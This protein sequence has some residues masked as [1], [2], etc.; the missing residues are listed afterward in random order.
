MGWRRQVQAVDSAVGLPYDVLSNRDCTAA[1]MIVA[2][3]WAQAAGMFVKF[4]MKLMNGDERM[5]SKSKWAG[6]TLGED[7]NT[8]MKFVPHARFYVYRASLSIAPCTH[9]CT[10]LYLDVILLCF[11]V[12]YPTH[13]G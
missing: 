12:K 2:E 3:L 5:L 6:A 4:T 1:V 8:P 11:T 10:L 9:T 13:L 7:V